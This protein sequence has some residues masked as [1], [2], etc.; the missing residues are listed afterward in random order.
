VLE[1]KKS[2]KLEGAGL[3]CRFAILDGHLQQLDDSSSMTMIVPMTVSLRITM[4]VMAT[5]LDKGQ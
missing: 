3:R 5:V 4:P 2:G 1:S